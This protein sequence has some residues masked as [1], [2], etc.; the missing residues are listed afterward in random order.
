MMTEE[1]WEQTIQ[2]KDKMIEEKNNLMVKLE[3]EVERLRSELR[4]IA[5]AQRHSFTD[6]EEF[7]TWAQNRARH[8]LGEET[9]T[10]TVKKG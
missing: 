3:M 4:Y 10:L 1:R 6:A 9:G 7:R 2:I 8:A 5:N